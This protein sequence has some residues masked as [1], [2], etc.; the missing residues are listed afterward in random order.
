MQKYARATSIF[1]YSRWLYR[2]SIYKGA[3]PYKFY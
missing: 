2:V 1:I 3:K